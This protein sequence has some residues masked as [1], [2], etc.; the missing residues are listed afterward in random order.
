MPYSNETVEIKDVTKLTF[1]AVDAETSSLGPATGIYS[2]P[3]LGLVAFSYSDH[4]L[5]RFIVFEEPDMGLVTVKGHAE[6]SP[7]PN[8]P[9][10][11]VFTRTSVA[12]LDGLLEVN[13]RVVTLYVQTQG[14]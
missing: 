13:D 7:D 3:G 4:A 12:S 10:A 2:T 5:G 8:D 11:P 6:G 9:R 1:V 14:C